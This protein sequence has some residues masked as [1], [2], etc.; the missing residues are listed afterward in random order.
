MKT[1]PKK[2]HAHYFS[3]QQDRQKKCTKS[4]LTDT[5]AYTGIKQPRQKTTGG[6]Y[7]ALQ[8]FKS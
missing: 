7:V 8:T 1:R 4:W 6:M 5:D 3:W 2:F